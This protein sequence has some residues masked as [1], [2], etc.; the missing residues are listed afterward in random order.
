MK[1]AVISGF[2]ALIGTLWVAAVGEW[3]NQHLVD[4][5]G[6]S[7][8]FFMETILAHPAALLLFIVG[9]ILLAFGLVS[10]VIEYVRKD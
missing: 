6:S 7:A 3:A 10:M 1:R 8:S 4:S 9:V 2:L 5:A